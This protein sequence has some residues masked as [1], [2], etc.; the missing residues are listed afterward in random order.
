MEPIR[1]IYAIIFQDGKAYVGQTGDM[2]KRQRDHYRRARKKNP[3]NRSLYAAL[4]EQ[5][6]NVEWRIIRRVRGYEA[7]ARAEKQAIIAMNA[8]TP[9]GYNLTLHCK[10]RPLT[11]TARQK[12]IAAQTGKVASAE[13]RARMSAGQRGRKHPPEVIEKIRKGNI[14]KKRTA[15]TRE[16][17]AAARRGAV[18]GAGGGL[19]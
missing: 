16:N 13:S 3:P 14:G 15:A 1:I 4:R 18:C 7:A 19:L 10:A 11:E 17:I 8:L 6:E 5:G 12:L 2:E 9:S